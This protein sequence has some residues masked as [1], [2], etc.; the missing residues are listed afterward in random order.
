MILCPFWTEFSIAY[1]IRVLLQTSIGTNT[2]FPTSFIEEAV[3]FQRIFKSYFSKISDLFPNFILYS[4][5]LHAVSI[6]VASSCGAPAFVFVVQYCLDVEGLL[7]FYMAH[8]IIVLLMLRM[9][10]V[11]FG[12]NRMYRLL[13]IVGAF[14]CC[15][16]FM[17][18]GEIAIF[19]SCFF[20]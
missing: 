19:V 11:L 12:L 8:R 4:I 3:F 1:K 10:L 2:I 6:T 15:L 17:K 5:S 13:W 9:S 20:H 7:C 14:S 18:R 16:Q